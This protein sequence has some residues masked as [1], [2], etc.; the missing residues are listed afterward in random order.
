MKILVI[1][2]D[3]KHHG[4]HSGY[5]QILKYI[6]PW[7]VLG[8]NERDETQVVSTWKMKYQWLFEFEAKKHR[9]EIDILH[10]MYGED[11]YRFSGKLMK[12]VPVVATFHQ[13]PELLEREVMH[14]D[15]RGRVGKWTHQL[16]KKRFE[17]LAAAIVTNINQKEVL[18]K[19][20]PADKIHV[21][22][23]GLHLEGLKDYYQNNAHNS[24]GKTI[25]AVGNWLRDWEFYFKVV[26][27]CKD[28]NFFLVNRNMPEEWMGHI[29]KYD[30]LTYFKNVSDEEL[31]ALYLRSDVQFHPVT[32]IAGSNAI[33]QGMALGSPLLLT[34]VD[35]QQFHN[36]G[37]FINLHAQHDLEDCVNQLTKLLSRSK[38]E[39][40]QLREAAHN[41][42]CEFTWENVAEKTKKLYQDIL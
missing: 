21:I 18:K 17:R 5:K 14:G 30:N 11:Y 4:E 34:D 32:G 42:A 24:D 7:K 16:S 13:P 37:E 38:E 36:Q 8:I 20:M 2:T 25:I 22:P 31:Y 1:R 6:A 23:L 3:F 19:V 9:N 29:D 33:L 10:V 41:Y 39:Q 28:W 40:Q 27:H 35:A 12:N 15:L 26:E